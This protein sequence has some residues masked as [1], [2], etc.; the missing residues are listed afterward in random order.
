MDF[1]SNTVSNI[2]N[3]FKLYILYRLHPFLDHYV[4]WFTDR[5]AQEE[6][7]GFNGFYMMLRCFQHFQSL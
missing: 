3:H 4:I 2:F 5:F 7:L 6:T 1:A